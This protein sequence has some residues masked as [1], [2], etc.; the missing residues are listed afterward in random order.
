MTELYHLKV[1]FFQNDYNKTTKY[2][3]YKKPTKNEN[4]NQTKS[5]YNT[6][7]KSSSAQ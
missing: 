6:S 5:C 1:Y 3:A 2:Q 4:N 7:C